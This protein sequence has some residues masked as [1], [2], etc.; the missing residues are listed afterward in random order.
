M[1]K[2]TIK[3]FK[4]DFPD[5]DAC[6][7]WL[8][9][10]IYPD[11]IFCEKCGRVTTHHRLTNRRCYSCDNCGTHVY[12]TANTIFHKSTTPLREWFRA[13][14]LM[15]STRCGIAAKQLQRELG[16]T[17]KTAWRMFHQI[18]KLLVEDTETLSG[19]VEMDETHIGGRHKGKR[20]RG[21]A[22][23]TIVAGVVKRHGKVKAQVVPDVKAKTLMPMMKAHV[24]PGSMVYTDEHL[25]YNGTQ[26]AGY[27]HRRIHHDQG[28]YVN[29]DVHTNNI[30]NFWGQLK[31]SLDGTHHAVS[32]KYLQRYCDE[33]AFRFNHRQ[34]E[35][36]IFLTWLAQV[37]QGDNQKGHPLNGG[38][39]S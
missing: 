1:D 5:N 37:C 26:K 10:H 24:L 36:H 22:G 18:R 8:K 34:D 15:S 3:N 16:V 23:K 38:M 19:E 11:G 12:P 9:N 39:P 29:G 17:Y 31:R 28:V 21:A 4:K 7:E 6:L 13:I 30:E 32:A 14:Y 27:Q 2:Y 25:S 33:F 35:Q 20:G